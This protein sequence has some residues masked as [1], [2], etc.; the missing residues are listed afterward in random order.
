MIGTMLRI[1]YEL[2]QQLDDSPIFQTYRAKD[3]VVGREVI[4]R[5][6]QQP[7][8]SEQSFLAA[9]RKVVERSASIPHPNIERMLEM[10]EHEGLPFIVCENS[11]GQPLSER[12][13][14]IA[15][16]S[17]PVALQMIAE[18][19]QG[20]VGLHEAG[21]THGDISSRNVVASP[22]NR[23]RVAMGGLWESLS[24][25]RTAGVVMLSQMA[26]YLAPDITNGEMPSPATDVYAVGVVLY[27]LLTGRLPFSA[28]TAGAMAVKHATA[29][30]PSVTMVNPKVPIPVEMLVK[31]CL[32]KNPA[33]RYADAR[34]VQSDIRQM[35][36][37]IRFGRPLVW[38][39]PSLTG[40]APTP[41]AAPTAVVTP[42]EPPQRVVPSVVPDEFKQA[43]VEPEM[44][45]WPSKATTAPGAA[46]APKPEE[47]EMVAPRMGAVR[48][49]LPSKGNKRTE[50]SYSDAVPKWLQW[51]GYT[52]LICFIVL[53]A[54]FVSW[55][56]TKPKL[57]KVPKV[58]F[59]NAAVVQQRLKAMGLRMTVLR[60]EANEKWPEN[61]I[62]QANPGDGKEIKAN[63][64][65][66]VIISSGSARV[67]MPRVTGRS[68]EDAQR[69]LKEYGLSIVEPTRT[70]FSE[71]Y[72]AGTVTRQDPDAGIL[73]E[74]GGK[75]RVTV[76]K[77]P[78]PNQ[79]ADPDNPVEPG[80]AGSTTRSVTISIRQETPKVHV[81][82]EI[83]DSMGTRTVYED[84][85][86]G[87]DRIEQQITFSGPGK[88]KIYYDDNP[89]P[90]REIDL[91][92]EAP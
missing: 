61:T 76:S 52:A 3:R 92:P 73:L 67:K 75:V 13:P 1:R 14:Q 26:P 55:N 56:A 79:E 30:V 9:V 11:I 2:L 71:K 68:L 15:P 38:P 39:V 16:F 27:E 18:V 57:L 45:K 66:S 69:A 24:S 17:V 22:E 23:I 37:A 64:A 43:P 70:A 7:F 60:R 77:G 82:M 25:S 19:C 89:A 36:D 32:A 50:P 74:R 80:V 72:P 5:I 62:L 12:I 78:E 84:D 10:D 35:L 46:P 4:V 29:P 28:D 86:V 34:T 83:E 44:E 51:F 58:T 20:L 21:V 87:G 81:R 42:I 85:H 63:G 88:L 59:Q 6:L 31:K 41:P 91:Q 54:S 48:K 40:A 53:V 90:V 47:K 49:D 33:D 8:S 65:V